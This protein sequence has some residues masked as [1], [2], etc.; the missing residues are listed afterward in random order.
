MKSS[1]MHQEQIKKVN[2]PWGYELWL[3]SDYND[4]KYAFKEIKINTGFKTSF[5]F[6]EFKEESNYVIEGQGVLYLSNSQINI[7]KFKNNEYLEKELLEIIDSLEKHKLFEGSLFHIRPGFV[8]AVASTKDLKMC[9]T[10]TLHLDDVFRINDEFGRRH[11]KIES[12][13]T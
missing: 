13:H 10:S 4:S 2:K 1:I 6:H 11:G 7:E 9:E 5:Q 3:A 12:E 8:H